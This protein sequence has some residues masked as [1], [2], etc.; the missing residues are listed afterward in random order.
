MR[1]FML[2]PNHGAQT[3]V[4]NEVEFTAGSED[5]PVEILRYVKELLCAEDLEVFYGRGVFE[6]HLCYIDQN[7]DQDAPGFLFMPDLSDTCIFGPVIIMGY[8]ASGHADAACSV[9]VKAAEVLKASASSYCTAAFAKAA[10]A[11]Y[12]AK[13]G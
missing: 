12:L 6:G 5:Q 9:R 3:V 4:F 11:A 13:A 1:M 10:A 8:T 7:Q 2:T